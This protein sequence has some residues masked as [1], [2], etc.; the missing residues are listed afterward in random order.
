MP[1][2][3]HSIF[4][5]SDDLPDVQ[6]PSHLTDTI[7]KAFKKMDIYRK[8]TQILLIRIH[9]GCKGRILLG[10]YREGSDVWNS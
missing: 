9:V 5:R 7:V 2:P 6:V 1:T 3:H 8:G 4:Y 10:S